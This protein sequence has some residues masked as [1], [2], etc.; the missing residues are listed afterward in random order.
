VLVI[1]IGHNAALNEVSFSG[2]GRGKLVSLARSPQGLDQIAFKVLF[3]S[4]LNI[5]DS[6]YE[7]L[8][9]ITG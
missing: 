5:A 3:W 1:L 9:E 2:W 8:P 6:S 7:I 4:L